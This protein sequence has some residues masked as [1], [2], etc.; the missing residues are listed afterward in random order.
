MFRPFVKEIDPWTREELWHA[1][2]LLKERSGVR[3]RFCFF[4]DGL[5]EY[6]GDPDHIVSVLESLRSWPDVKLCVSS[7]PWNE[8]IDAFGRHSDPQ[9]ALEDL[10]REDIKIYVRDTLEENSRFKALKVRDNR[11]K[12]LVLEIVDKAQGVFLWVILVVLKGLRNADRISDLQRRLQD[13]PD[14]LEKYFGHMIA[15][16]E[17][18][19][20]EQT[21]RTFIYALKAKEPLSLMT[22]SLLDEEDLDR[23]MAAPLN[24][25]THQDILSRQDDM[26][27]RLNGRCKGLLEVAAEDVYSHN[28]LSLG[29]LVD[30]HRRTVRDFLLTKDMH[31][32][33]VENLEPG[34]EPNLPICKALVAQLKALDYN[35]NESQRWLK[36]QL[37][38]ELAIFA[39]QVE[40]ET[41]IAQS[42]A[43]DGASRCLLKQ[44]H[45]FCWIFSEFYLFDILVWRG[46]H[47]CVEEQL[48]TRKR[49]SQSDK[50]IL[51]HNSLKSRRTTETDSYDF[52]LIMIDI[53]LKHGAKSNHRYSGSTV[54][55]HFV[56]EYRDRPAFGNNILAVIERLLS[57]G[58][59]LRE[60]I[61]I[62]Q[63]TRTT[64]SERSANLHIYHKSGVNITKSAQ[65]ILIDL[66]GEEKVAEMLRKVQR[67]D[68]SI[69]SE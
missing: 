17:P 42:N 40:R 1:I 45:L 33:I 12:D 61:I 10:T 55:G 43:L 38:D 64:V 60:R 52:D 15:S 27:R 66:L 65:E 48:V 53:L 58:A 47:L 32:M 34:F 3:A 21:A 41:H 49:W 14:T 36:L 67:H 35:A 69:P 22:Y 68:V 9:L 44:A 59:K 24:P 37:F 54:W 56:S 2:G 63:K 8:F 13:F 6:D 23:V 25:L 18:I 51:L 5:D 31:N 46:L 7:R 57:Y 16:V 19:Y 62:N 28:E 4:I 26:R 50:S 20:K 39:R 11:S 29:P 30:F